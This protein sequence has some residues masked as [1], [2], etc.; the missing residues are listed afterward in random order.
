MVKSGSYKTGALAVGWLGL[1]ATGEAQYIDVVKSELP[2]ESWVHPDAQEIDALVRGEKDMGLVCWSWGYRCIVMGEYFLLTG[3]KSVLPGLEIYAKALAQGQDVAGRW[4][5]R[6]ASPRFDGRL[7]GYSHINQPTLTCYIGLLLARKSGIDHPQIDRAIERCH[8]VFSRYTGKGALPYGNHSPF[9]HIFNNNGTSASLAIAMSLRGD[10]EGAVFFSRQAAAAHDIIET[11]HA[12]HYF[13][14]LWTPLGANLAGPQVTQQFFQR[15]RW[16]HTLSRSWDD[17]FTFDGKESNAGQSSGSHLLAHCLPRRALYITGKEC[18]RSLWLDD[19]Q[20]AQVIGWSQIDYKSKSIN[21]LI[22]LFDHPAPQLRRRA[23]AELRDRPMDFAPRLETILTQGNE[24]QKL[25]AIGFLG[26]QCPAE[27]V[28][29]HLERLSG[30][31]TDST[32]SPQIRA[33]AA[34]SMS[35]LGEAAH[36]HYDDLLRFA[37]EDRPDDELRLIDESIA[38]SIRQLAPDP[39]ASG[40]VKDKGLFYK[41]VLKLAGHPLQSVRADAMSL[42]QKMPLEDF[43]IVSDEVKKVVLNRDPSY[44]S[45]HNP[46]SSVLA[47]A[48]VLANLNIR[49]GLDWGWA[50]LAT[51]DGKGSFKINAVMGILAAYGPHAKPY[52]EK[53]Q[54]DEGLFKSV[55]QGRCKKAWD[56]IVAASAREPERALISFDEAQEAELKH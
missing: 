43:Y 12:T 28:M 1:L 46:G 31:V 51:P 16:L 13:N 3:D 56:S 44:T 8:K 49:E 27:V 45:Y 17:R 50:T 20:A 52:V 33:A 25:S 29:P 32:Q 21:Q 10:R 22:E 24:L 15:T 34:E 37:A 39:F 35:W 26:Y 4:G 19:T 47:G 18:D 7:P 23:I 54:A 9:T 42:I 30:L 2:K 55:S 41:V 36:K 14:I 38:G 40:V 48:T 11:G 5:H 6:L 53:I